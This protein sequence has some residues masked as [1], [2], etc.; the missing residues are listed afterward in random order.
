MALKIILELPVNQKMS[1]Y[2][3]TVC[4]LCNRCSDEKSKLPKNLKAKDPN[5]SSPGNGILLG[6]CVE[7]QVDWFSF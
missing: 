7:K 3:N 5:N 2:Y 1:H 6:D 4:F